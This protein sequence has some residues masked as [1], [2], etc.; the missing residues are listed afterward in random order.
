MV[1]GTDRAN[2]IVPL[3]LGPHGVDPFAAAA[4]QAHLYVISIIFKAHAAFS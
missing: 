2:F 1:M 3:A 4:S